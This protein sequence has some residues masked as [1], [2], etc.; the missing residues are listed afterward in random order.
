MVTLDFEF[1]VPYSIPQR[2][3]IHSAREQLAVN[4]DPDIHALMN[5]G[6][7]EILAQDSMNVLMEDSSNNG[8]TQ[9]DGSNGK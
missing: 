5:D 4:M 6:L 3:Y 9:A 8:L 7:E 2:N 1:N